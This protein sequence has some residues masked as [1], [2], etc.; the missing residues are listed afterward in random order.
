MN[1]AARTSSAHESVADPARPLT[2]Q[3][4]PDGA[5]AGALPNGSDGATVAGPPVLVEPPTTA[6]LVEDAVR[7][8]RASLVEL[9]GGSSLADIG[10]LG[11]A[12]I[13]L[14]AA[15]PSGV[16][17]LFAGRPTR[18]SN[19]FREGASLPAARRRARAV[20]VRSQEHAQRY[21][22]APTYLAIGVTTW[23]EE[24]PSRLPTDDVAALAH[25][26]GSSH[27]RTI[28]GATGLPADPA[29]LAHDPSADPAQAAQGDHEA[30]AGAP[31][32]VSGAVG[33]EDATVNAAEAHAPDPVLPRTV[34]APVLLRPLTL[35]PRGDSETDYDLTLEPTVE[36]NPLLART[37]RAH[38]G[39]I[40]PVTLARSAFT[41]A[42]FDPSD[43]L[44]RITAVG[45]AVLGDFEMTQRVLVGTFVH[46]G[47]VLVDDLD[48][49]AS[50]LE[51]HEVVAALA[52]SDEAATA[53]ERELPAPR[54][55]DADPTQE[56]GVGDLDPAQRHVID[57]LATGSHLFVD[58]PAGSDVA[59]TLAAVVAE[60]AASGRSILYVPGHRRAADS[61]THRLETLG[62]DGLILD[63]EPEPTWRATA[64][65][66][67][68]A[69]MAAEAEVVDTDAVARVRDGLLGARA[70]LSGYVESLHL[71]REPWG[72]SAYAALQALARLTAQR[73]A[74][75]TTVRLGPEVT[76][77][78]G[79]E[80]RA[81]LA[82]RLEGAADV[83]AFTLRST[84][85]PWF[86]ADITSSE[87]AQDALV[88]VE[89]LAGR[90]LPEL[91]EQ[92]E[93]VARTT[94]LTPATSVRQWGEQLTMLGGMRGTLDAFQP[95][96]FERTATDLVEATGTRQWR[97]DNG[98]DMGWAHR[99]R[100][101]KQAKDMLR[102]GVRVADLH[103]A[104]VEVQAQRAVWQAQCPR[105]GW[106]TLPEGLAA[107]EDTFEAVR[108]DL[109]YLEPV[110]STTPVGADLMDLPLPE[111][112]ARLLSL[113]EEKDAL[114]HLPARTAALRS[115]R[116]E[117][118]GELLDD[119]S[120]RRVEKELVG[121]E[122]DLAWWSSVFEQILS[123]DP[124]LAGQDGAGLEALAG[125]FRELDR[126]H[127][128]ALSAP[129]RVA[130]RE[131]LGGAMRDHR[132]EAEALFTE[133]LEGRLT[134]LRDAHELYPEIL[135]RLRPCV[136]ASPTLVPHLFT[137]A[138][139]VDLVIL[140]AVQHLPVEL[141]L[142]SL[143][144]GRQVVVVGDPR[145]ASGS[146]VKELAAVLPTVA[147]S[148]GGARR[149]PYLTAFLVAH[150]YEGVLRPSPLPR[151]EPLVHL[152]L[153]DGA[154]MPDP[155]SGAVES[156]QAEVDRVVEIA[157]EHAMTRPEESLAIVTVS[158]VHAD[159][160]RDA[161]L[162]EVRQNPA[163]AAFFS[164]ARAEPV[165][166]AE[167]S[168]VAGLTRDAIVLSVGYGRTPHGRVLHRFGV[169]NAAGG[170][171]MLLDTL[172][173]TRRRLHVVTCFTAADLD[174]E[175]LRGHGAKLLAE[176]LDLAEQ[177]NGRADQ[178]TLGN[179]VD[180]GG[181][182]DRLVIDLA[183]RLWRAGL[184]VETDYGVAGGDR[185]P[186]VV[187]H[188]DLPGEL[189]VAVL[190]D[191][192]A[193]VAERSVRVRDRQI[194]ERLESAGWV[195]AQVWSAA[196]FL[197][198]AKEAERIR[199]VVQAVRDARLPERGGIAQTGGGDRIVVVPVVA[200]D[201]FGTD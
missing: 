86:G 160:I 193:Y 34:R 76:L 131:H 14:T 181:N 192:D 152:D 115:L 126:T 137:P 189:L 184:V 148:A 104:L 63:I 144:R 117:G 39:L 107:I 158:A 68:L 5:S 12:V 109:E 94:G 49:L 28:D 92:V 74:P 163:L 62:L 2:D 120:A 61:L 44:T 139:T 143:A 19:L 89:R 141:V 73:P 187:G 90:T 54:V 122:L 51:R 183:E 175:R 149:D 150:G 138:R 123:Q 173:S 135:R 21:G 56:R 84:S 31:H 198:P 186:L 106:P 71:V 69:A 142:S 174:P 102:P 87:G 129:V 128:T 7:S 111:L 42:G 75:A 133:L 11:D 16:A 194:A 165:V 118:L 10:L 47:Q 29:D 57:T 72:V 64:S 168:A 200:D 15:H 153:V 81:E 179:G 196:A 162:A 60:A 164:G 185:I 178:V 167:V 93:S 100:L 114:E 105:G 27:G 191:D 127:I 116:D 157:I 132:S 134:S 13:D 124:A 43:A 147:L 195:V 101:R 108:L 85:T 53:L 156:T 79:A 177:R 66:R 112:A 98:I 130:V 83:G 9:A 80:R 37:L 30:A 3:T 145:A 199:R 52:G 171:A 155:T 119:L 35:T 6:E 121:P 159:R 50:G 169:L 113:S 99:R 48:E 24:E 110:L 172:G 146:A 58:A 91:R 17:Q 65:H 82:A 154:G 33:P 32:A 97:A 140:D 182:P 25:V 136:V 197:D 55:G 95:L 161:L 22:V 166:V 46:P 8:W 151:A 103:A 59:G 20:V 18:L 170:D 41:P 96:I 4:A 77:R 45:R 23:T 38:G 40:D 201:E 188:P 36:I 176:V 78:I 26:A 190:T 70:Q 67:L 125:R 1:A 88:R 180:V